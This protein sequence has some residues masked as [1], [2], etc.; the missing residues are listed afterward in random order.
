MTDVVELLLDKGADVDT[1]NGD[2][3]SPLFFAAKSNN[4][5]G[6]SILLRHGK[7]FTLLQ[8]SLDVCLSF[9]VITLDGS[10]SPFFYFIIQLSFS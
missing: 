3:C 7:E 2:M 9:R 6:A 5:F 1:T 10:R 4:Q 8:S